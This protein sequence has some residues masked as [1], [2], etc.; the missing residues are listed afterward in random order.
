MGCGRA[1]IFCSYRGFPPKRE[2]EYAPSKQSLR[3]KEVEG[4]I[5]I[6][7]ANETGSKI[8][9][10]FRT[11]LYV[12]DLLPGSPLFRAT[13]GEAFMT[14]EVLARS[15]A[16]LRETLH[17]GDTRTLMNMRRSG[18]VEAM[19]G[20]VH[21]GHLA[22]KMANSIDQAQDLQATYIPVDPEIVK[23]AD[24]ARRGAGSS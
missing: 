13:D 11:A 6:P 19:A 12:A 20:G 1:T 5:T 2:R 10:L 15:F 14:K 3:P 16:R 18:A 8:V 17:P 23:F 9:H 22:A 7:D 21:A 4:Q 24:E